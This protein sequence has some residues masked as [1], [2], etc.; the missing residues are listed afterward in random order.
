MNNKKHIVNLEY[1]REMLQICPRIPSQQFEEPPFKEAIL[2]F[3][4]ELGHN[5]EIKMIIDVNVNKLHQPWR[6]FAAV[7]NKCLSGKSTG[8]D[9]IRL[10]QAQILWGM[11]HKKNV[12][13]SYL[14]WEDFVYQV[15]HKDAKKSNDMYYPRFTKVIVNFFMT[16]DL[17]I[18]RRNKV[19]WHFDRDDHMFTTIKIVSIHKDT[20]E[21]DAIFPNEL[22]NEDIKNSKSY[23]E[24]YAIASG[25]EP[26]KIK[27]SA[28]A[29]EPAKKKQL[30][31]TSKA[32]GLTVLSEVALTEAEQMKLAT[33]RSLI[34]THISHASGSGADEGTGRD[35]QMADAQQTNVLTTQVTKDTHVII[36][37]VNLEDVSVTTTAEPPL[38]SATT[39]PP[40]PTSII[41]Y[42]Q[43]TPVPLTTN[44]PS[45]SIIVDKYLDNQ[46]NEAVK[47]VVQLQSDRLRDEAQA[48]N[49][50]FLNKL[51]ENIKKIIKEQVKEQVKVQ[52]SKI[53]L[54]IEKT[55]N[56]QLE[57]KVLTRSSS[58]SKTSHAITANLSELELKNI[59]IDKMERNKSIHRSVE[60]KNLHKA[61][62]TA[63]ESDKLILDTYGDTVTIKR[64]RDDQDEDEEPSARSNQASKRRRAGKEPESTSAPKEKTSMSTEKSTK[65]SKSH[66]KSA[67]KSA[68]AEEPMHTTKR[69]RRTHTSGVHYRPV[70]PWISNLARKDNSC[71]SF[72]ELMDTSLDF[73]AFVM[74]RLKVDTLTLELLTGLT[75]KLM[76]GSCKSLVELEYFFKEVYKVTTNQSD[77][78]NLE[79]Q[80][81]PHDLRKPP[82]LIPNSR[83]RRVIP[84]DHFINNDLEYLSGGVSS[85]KYTTSVTKTKAADYGNIK[86]I[87]DLVPNRMWSQVSVSYDK[88]AL[89]GISHWG[90]KRQ[91][92]YGFAANRESARDVYSKR[93]IIAVTELQIVEW[94]NYKHLDWI[95]V[96]RDDNKLYKFKEGDFNRLRIQDI[97]DMML[98]FVQGK[99]LNLTVAER[100]AFNVSL[101]MFTRSVIIQ[102]RVE[103]LQLGVESYQ[104]KINLTKPNTYRLDLKRKEAY[105]AYSNPKGFIYQKKDKKNRLMRIDELHKFSDGTLNNV[106]TALDDP[107]K[108]IRMQYLPQTIWRRSDKDKAG[109]MIQ[110]IDKQLKSRRIM[111]SL[112]KFVGGRLYEGDLRLLQR[113]I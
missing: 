31:K 101:R 83:G 51:D 66:H 36:T 52:V 69:F 109:A 27:T 106:R 43:Q 87:E 60:Q 19:N 8:Y 68:L 10:S 97:K 5:R 3:L 48:K 18:P 96:R 40:P 14:L 47:V 99:L 81:Y 90:H 111:W 37:S 26:P 34:Q 95:T 22:P 33:K 86:W 74:N 56:E 2:T 28:K 41:T 49:E 64:C 105:T 32:K 102:R 9:I 94:H 85:R 89:R 72:N 91:Q 76:K 71:D 21:Y 63:Y 29:I 108:G 110:A 61:L 46:M 100:L 57:N 11:Y 88:H 15:E 79:G 53:L 107:L 16:K 59:L 82:S 50:D 78:N 58:E 6:S 20:Q 113:T 44:V 17:S 42:L 77:W 98:L 25:A 24:Y 73:S 62:V 103:D 39:L 1:F 23:T 92:L 30:A 65:G 104:K 67:S 35:I 80:Q 12:D 38:L 112:E 13:F 75:F 84:F 45:S 4:R 54:K 70:Q 7:I 55:I 93:I